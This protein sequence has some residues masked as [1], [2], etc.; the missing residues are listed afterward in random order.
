MENAMAGRSSGPGRRRIIGA[1][2]ALVIAAGVGAATQAPQGPALPRTPDGRPDLT[3]MWTNATLTTLERPAAFEGRPTVSEQEAAEFARSFLENNTTDR[4]PDDPQQDVNLAYQDFY[5]DRGTD[6]ALVNGQRRTSLIVDPPDGRLPPMTAEAQARQA[7]RRGGAVRP[8]SDAGENVAS[9][10]PGAFDNVE[11]RPLAERCILSFGS[12]SGP[13]MLPVL[14][15][16]HYQFV[17]TAD[18]LMVLVEMVHDARI[19][20]VNG[21]HE[22]SHIRKWLG[23]SVGRWEGDTFVAVTTNFTD[24]T[25][26][27]GSTENLKVT[28]RFTL[29]DADH[30]LYRFTIEDPQTWTRPWTAEIPFR[31]TTERM[32]EYACHEAN[33]ALEGIMRGARQQEAA[34]ARGG[35]KP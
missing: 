21:T 33:Y 23:D 6:L 1:V 27:R 12:S 10:G 30:L 4:R 20:R 18:H 32:Y 16:N 22:P 31:R 26:Y 11:Q 8:T 2:A 5:I 19:I 34:A 24:K 14:Y 15:N 28:E 13:P 9:R 17:Q 3:G 35:Q 29:M 25:Q 7:A